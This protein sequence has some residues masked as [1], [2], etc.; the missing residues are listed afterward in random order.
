[1]K[2]ISIFLV[3]II[4]CIAFM[5]TGCKSTDKNTIRVSEVTHSLFYAPF[6]VA[7]NE[8]YFEDEG[9]TIK[10]TNAGGSDAVMTALT[11]KSADIG[12][13]GPEAVVYTRNQGM[14]NAPKIFAQLTNCDGS[15]LMGRNP[16][17]EGE[18]FDWTSLRGKYIIAGRPGGMPAMTLQYILEKYGLKLGDE[19][20]ANVDTIFDLGVSF[21]MTAAT[22]LASQGDYVTMFE[23]L[24]SECDTAGTA[25]IVASL[26]EEEPNV[27]Y[28]V[29]TATTK[30]MNNNSEQIEKFVRALKK[31][32]DYLMAIDR[33]DVEIVNALKPSF[34]TTSD[35]LIVSAVKNYMRIGAYSSDFALSETSWNK[36]IEIIENAGVITDNIATYADSVNNEYVR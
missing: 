22:F 34:S 12:L 25:Y 15:F 1:M 29:F 24:A 35:A 23:P 8:G 11:S 7:I 3:M 16:I 20:G 14:T 19:L 18:T 4:S 6:Y 33:T 32:Y 31:G 13:M 30:Y 2:K 26:G 36:L 27:P 10:L 9:L 17:P 5:V 21:N 28:T